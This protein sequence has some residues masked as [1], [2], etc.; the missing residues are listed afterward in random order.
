MPRQRHDTGYC[1]WVHGAHA[2]GSRADVLAV[3]FKINLL[4]A[5]AGERLTGET[6]ALK[7]ARTLTV[8]AAGARI[9]R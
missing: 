4:P 5:S 3:E 9:V 2:D 7:E 8:K 1:R 6:F